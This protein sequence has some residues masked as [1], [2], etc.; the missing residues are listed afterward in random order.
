MRFNPLPTVLGATTA[1][2]VTTVLMPSQAQAATFTVESGVTSVFLDT[3]TLS[4]VG[5][6]LTGTVGEVAAPVSDEFLVG[7]NITPDTDFTFSD[8]AGFTLVGGSI[9][10][11]GGVVFNGDTAA[12]LAVGDFSI[13]FDAARAD[14]TTGATGFFVQ[15]VLTTG[16]VLF[17]IAGVVPSLEGDALTIDGELLVSEELSGVL[18][19]PDL[20]GAAVG[21]AQ[22]NASVSE[23][24]ASVPEPSTAIGLVLAGAG[25]MAARRKLT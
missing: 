21:S 5:L 1:A 22:V 23:T 15:D 10:H 2:L 20:V 17:D 7:F 12:E 14:E 13:G 18:Q 8:E 25:V 11:T 6:T 3:E 9:E 16:A 4:S 24:M 19:N